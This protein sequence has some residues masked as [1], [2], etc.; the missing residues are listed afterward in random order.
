MSTLLAA[1]AMVYGTTVGALYL[2]QRR[3]LYLPDPVPA[4]R[5]RWGAADMALLEVRTEDGLTLTGW[6]RGPREP[7]RPTVA[8]FHG[9]AGHLGLRSF[10]A[11]Q[12]INAGYGVLLAS[13]RGWGGNPG[14]PTEAGLYR[15]ARAFLDRLSGL[16]VAEQRLVV[17]GESLGT[18]VAVQMATERAVRAVVLEAP[19]TTIPD[20]GAK[21]FPFAPVRTLMR[22]R[23]DSLSKIGGI[24]APLLIVHGERDRTVP[25]RLGRR[26]FAAAVEPKRA[27]W[28]PQAGHNDVF[29]H[30]A[31]RAVLEFLGE[32]AELGG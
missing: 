16:G 10:K 24:R 5:E 20:V 22:D 11:R 32:V 12:F 3:L 29:D 28:L 6:H 31:G 14:R 18:G 2:V 25:V 21:R 26:L 19:Y 7:G 17:Y 15:D 8:L 4:D 23:F 13:Y 1:G 9:N 27:V 30:G